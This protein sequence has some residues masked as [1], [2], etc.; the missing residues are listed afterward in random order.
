MTIAVPNAVLSAVA[1]AAG[2][3]ADRPLIVARLVARKTVAGP[4]ARLGDHLPVKP[5]DAA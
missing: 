4:I 2:R 1:C 3:V 5:S